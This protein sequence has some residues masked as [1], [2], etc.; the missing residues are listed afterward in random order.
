MTLIFQALADD[1][2]GAS[3]RN[4]KDVESS[5]NWYMYLLTMQLVVIF[6]IAS[7][8]SGGSY[9]LSMISIYSSTNVHDDDESNSPSTN[10]Q[11]DKNM[12]EKIMT[13]DIMESKSHPMT[14]MVSGTQCLLWAWVAMWSWS[15]WIVRT[16]LRLCHSHQLSSW[17]RQPVERPSGLSCLW[18]KDQISHER[19]SGRLEESGRKRLDWW[20]E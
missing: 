12:K 11:N 16:T 6:A 15:A 5:A 8:F 3:K 20:R 19:K 1:A 13:E 7:S 14:S 10:S 18:Y 17:F 4:V 2:R 9:W